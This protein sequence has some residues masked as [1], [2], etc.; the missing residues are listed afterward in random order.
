MYVLQEMSCNFYIHFQL[1]F[2]FCQYNQDSDFKFCWTARLI[3]RYQIKNTADEI[4]TNFF[5]YY[6]QY[7]NSEACDYISQWPTPTHQFPYL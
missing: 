5:S 7:N 6:F 3:N 1:G 2:G 4:A